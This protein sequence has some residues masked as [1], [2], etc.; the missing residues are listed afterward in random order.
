[1]ICAR[2]GDSD[3]MRLLRGLFSLT[4]G[5]AQS[6][7]DLR[8]TAENGQIMRM[9]GND[10]FKSSWWGNYSVS[11]FVFSL[12]LVFRIFFFYVPTSTLMGASLSSGA[13]L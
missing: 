13:S 8:D 6:P 4:R 9:L 5:F 7:L 3:V 11:S 2:T 12:S 1:M 10:H